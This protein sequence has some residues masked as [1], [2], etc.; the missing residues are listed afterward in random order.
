[1]EEI[2]FRSL[3][4]H[5][6]ALEQGEYSAEELLSLYL[7]RIDA[8]DERLGAFLTLDREEATVA[9]RRSDARRREGRA[10]HALDGIPFAANTPSSSVLRN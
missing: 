8:Y 10:L 7:N 6:R 1:M 9:A 3:A 4:A 2:L 5:Q